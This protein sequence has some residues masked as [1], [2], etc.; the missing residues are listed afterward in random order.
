V[1]SNYVGTVAEILHE[2]CTHSASERPLG[3]W[4]VPEEVD[5][6]RAYATKQHSGSK[7]GW[8]R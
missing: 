1:I 5:D 6:T 8:H 3:N 4:Q 2:P 7:A